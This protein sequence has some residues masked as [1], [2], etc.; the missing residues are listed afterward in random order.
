MKN[1]L[2]I[3]IYGFIVLTLI[4]FYIS[5]F[6]I[7]GTFL[8]MFPILA[9]AQSL[10][11]YGDAPDG[12]NTFYPVMPG[13]QS[14]TGRF[15]TRFT[16]TNSRVGEPGVHH[17]TIDQEWF[18]YGSSAE[19]GANDPNDPDGFRN[20]VNND[21]FDDG[22]PSNPFFLVLKS[23]PPEATITF[24]VTI[25]SNAPPGTR[26][27]NM[28]IDWDQSGDW[29]NIPGA[30]PEWVLVNFPVNEPPGITQAI[31][32]N[33]PW[34]L[35]A[36]LSPQV[37]WMRM[38]LSRS[39]VNQSQFASSGGWDG[40]GVF[41]YGETEDFLFHPQ[42]PHSGPPPWNSPPIGVPPGW[43]PTNLPDIELVPKSQFVTHGWPARVHV[44]LK[45]SS[46][47]LPDYRW[48]VDQGQR[49]S[50]L[51]SPGSG[52]WISAGTFGPELSGSIA[53][54]GGFTPP[55][56]PPNGTIDWITI[57]SISHTI[58]PPIEEWPV[59]VK[60][61][62][63]GIRV[64]TKKAVVHIVHS[65]IGSF[66]LMGI[67][68]FFLNTIQN[69]DLVAELKEYLL[70]MING[71]CNAFQTG[72]IN[73]AVQILETLRLQSLTIGL[74]PD[75]AME[76]T[77]KIDDTIQALNNTGPVPVPQIINPEEGSKIKDIV[78]ITVVTISPNVTLNKLEYTNN[79][80]IWT[81]IWM[82]HN[83]SDGWSFDW[84]TKSLEDGIYII[85]ATMENITGLK[86]TDLIY[87][88]VDNSSPEPQF[89][90]PTE[91]E[92]INDILNIMITTNDY[93]DDIRCYFEI[94]LDGNSWFDIG[95][96]FDGENAWTTQLNT[97]QLKAGNYVIRSTMIDDAGN[98]NSAIVRVKI[99]HEE[100]IMEL[101]KGWSMISLPLITGETS[102]SSLFPGATVVYSYEKSSGY[103]RVK[104]LEAE[105]GYWIHL[106]SAQ[107]YTFN[108]K[109]INDFK[110]KVNE[111]KWEMIGG[112]SFPAKASIKNGDIEIIY[113]YTPGIGYKQVLE[114]E[115]LEPGRGYWI[116]IS[117][118]L[119]HATV[120]IGNID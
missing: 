56:T 19:V 27:V 44:I 85:K 28:L 60:A 32:A 31:T 47:L 29:R 106:D 76:I 91:G 8:F 67:Y 59:K 16:T 105:R 24:F 26:Y 25:A 99:L 112:C 15:P 68:D 86:G 104:E 34:G 6:I 100:F 71:S 117:N 45:P 58:V 7:Q 42:A 20:L 83:G 21:A 74:P 49:G 55:T 113:K 48:A 119:E 81:E 4:C 11:D 30:T 94:S 43:L 23:L 17:I 111:E 75:L 79:G 46:A 14:V 108:G 65:G 93:E 66:G 5:L 90:S 50:F 118:I 57:E 51:F 62:W 10:S 12:T 116:L 114:S 92:T 102:V 88:W 54:M 33:I 18:G 120:H 101:P 1:L 2:I 39:Q 77:N 97:A 69:L 109:T 22:L 3:R 89:I 107:T 64:Q 78:T 110:L 70:S 96:D 61:R 95:K 41:Q 103:I 98:E 36:I 53:K 35:G 80:N 72:N 73:Q 38:T 82:D 9:Q 13:T 115:S 52:D 84:D 37:F 63:P 87:I 40:S